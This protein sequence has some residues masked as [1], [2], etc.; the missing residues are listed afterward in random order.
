LEIF[1][2]GDVAASSTRFISRPMTAHLLV[3]IAGSRLRGILT[4]DE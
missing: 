2:F 1:A 4:Q 3:R